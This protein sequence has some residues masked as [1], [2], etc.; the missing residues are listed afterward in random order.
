M[1]PNKIFYNVAGGGSYL[2]ILKSG[3][4]FSLLA[5]LVL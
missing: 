3:F 2:Q 4:F 1:N 5:K